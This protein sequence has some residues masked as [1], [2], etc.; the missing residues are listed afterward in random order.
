MKKANTSENDQFPQAYT[1]LGMVY[2]EQRKWKEAEG[3]LKKAV[4]QGAN[5][6]EV[7]FQLGASLNQQKDYAGAVKALSQGLKLN[8][9]TRLMLLQPT[10]SSVEPTWH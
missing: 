3:A 8:V 5:A 4:Q 1:L 10:T 7:Y 9:R 2:N 6:S